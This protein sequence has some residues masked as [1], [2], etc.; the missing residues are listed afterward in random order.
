MSFQVFEDTV[1]DSAVV[2]KKPSATS[3]KQ[4][5]ETFLN[6]LRDCSD[7]EYNDVLCACCE[8]FKDDPRYKTNLEYAQCWLELI[9]LAEEIDDKLELLHVMN[10]KS[11]GLNFADFYITFAAVLES[12]ADKEDVSV[13]CKIF[14]SGIKRGAKPL[15]NLQQQYAQFKQRCGLVANIVNQPS[16]KAPSPKKIVT[17]QKTNNVVELAKPTDYKVGYNRDAIYTTQGELSFEENR[18]RLQR[19]QYVPK[20]KPAHAIPQKSIPDEVIINEKPLKS[21]YVIK[22]K[23]KSPMQAPLPAKPTPQVTTASTKTLGRRPRESTALLQPSS[24]TVNTKL[25]LN[26]IESMFH[27]DIEDED[28]YFEEKKRMRKKQRIEQ[29]P[30]SAPLEIFQ[31]SE[32]DDFPIFSDDQPEPVVQESFPIYDEN[33]QPADKSTDPVAAGPLANHSLRTPLTPCLSVLS[34]STQPGRNCSILSQSSVNQSVM[35]AANLLQKQLAVIVEKSGP[36]KTVDHFSTFILELH[37]QVITPSLV[38]EYGDRFINCSGSNLQLELKTLK[39]TLNRKESF[40]LRTPDNKLFT[41]NGSLGEGAYAFVAA[42]TSSDY[43]ETIALKIQCPP[44]P[45]EF[46]VADQIQQRLNQSAYAK[47]F[48]APTG[49]YLYDN[50]SLLLMPSAVFGN[51]SPATLQDLINFYR[52]QGKHM[53]EVLVIYYTVEL[54]KMIETLHNKCSIIHADIKPDV[55][56]DLIV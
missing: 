15:D 33:Q 43:Q 28:N 23:K 40:P 52:S 44:C 53:D 5:L 2:P 11:I 50:A 46:Y 7:E 48:I 42:A 21:E 6:A 38:K 26:D 32:V 18:A 9:D 14:E 25:A 30:D 16:L 10:Q 34:T 31:D 54:L 41:I 1:E 20:P 24:P 55:R 37:Q 47:R 27:G 8:T 29:L 36:A 45:W 3:G 4:S 22:D 12:T 39:S 19:Y 13:A 17:V 51:S 49:M 56:F 35:E